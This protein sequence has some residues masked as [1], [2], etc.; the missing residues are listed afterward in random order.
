MEGLPIGAALPE[1]LGDID[2]ETLESFGMKPLEK[3]R[4]HRV[5]RKAFVF[6]KNAAER[7][8]SPVTAPTTAQ[9]SPVHAI[10]ENPPMSRNLIIV[11]AMHLVGDNS[12][13]SMLE[14]R[15]ISSRQLSEQD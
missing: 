13:L 11:G 14:D 1:D 15:G 8:A 6:N 7:V 10:I 9:S 4:F 12:V 2:D 5:V 3:K